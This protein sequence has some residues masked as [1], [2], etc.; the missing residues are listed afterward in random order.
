V[1]A[2]SEEKSNDSKD[3]FYEELEWLFNH[4]PKYYTKILGEDFNAKV[5]REDIFKL[6][7]GNDSLHQDCNDSGVKIVKFATSKNLVVKS[8]MFLHSYIHTYTWISPDGKTHNQIDYI[9]IDRRWH[10]SIHD[11]R[12][13]RRAD[14]DTDHYLMF[15]TVMERLEVSK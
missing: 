3:R 4:F 12:S 8:M 11:A 13:F 5:G 2:P 15:A 1:H 7:F 9:L 6:T 10:S 14:C